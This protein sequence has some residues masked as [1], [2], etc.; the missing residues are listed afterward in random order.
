M[1]F[2]EK[3]P[4][5]Q[6]SLLVPNPPSPCPACSPGPPQLCETPP[7]YLGSCCCRS[8]PAG[9]HIFPL[10]GDRMAALAS[11][12]EG[13]RKWGQRALQPPATGPASPLCAIWR[14]WGKGL[15]MTSGRGGLRKKCWLP[16]TPDAISV[17][18]GAGKLCGGW[19]IGEKEER[20]EEMGT[21]LA[22]GPL[23]TANES[24]PLAT[25]LSPLNLSPAPPQVLPVDAPR[26]SGGNAHDVGGERR[27]AWGRRRPPCSWVEDGQGGRR[28]RAGARWRVGEGERVIGGAA[29]A[30]YRRVP[31]EAPWTGMGRP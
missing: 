29:H 19:R 22:T 9:H 21:A 30:P 26:G 13:E 31:S 8:S 27:L 15:T 16:C 12:T 18:E 1:A 20:W 3:A 17:G 25:P 6:S 24:N 2:K 23:S 4:A 11:A 7:R 5:S 28:G 10:E 14:S